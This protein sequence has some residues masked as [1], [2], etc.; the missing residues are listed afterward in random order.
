MDGSNHPEL[1]DCLLYL[2][3]RCNYATSHDGAGFNKIDAQFGN[4]LATKSKQRDLSLNQHLAARKM[5][6][7][8]RGQLA[9]G[10]LL[11]PDY[12]TIRAF[13]ANREA[14][15]AEAAANRPP[16]ELRIVG[17]RLLVSFPFNLEF[18]HALR[19]LAMSLNDARTDDG[20]EAAHWHWDQRSTAWNLPA[21]WLEP[22]AGLF[23][24]F[25][26]NE[27]AK[28]RIAAFEAEREAAQ[29]RAEAAIAAR[30]AE[31]NGLLALV[32]LD[33]DFAGR[34]LRPY[35]KE[36]IT[37]V[38][39]QE[40]LLL[41]DD[42][43]LGKTLQSAVV[44]TA[45]QKLYDC[46]AFI[47]CRAGLTGQWTREIERNPLRAEIY[48]N[49]YLSIPQPPNRPFVLTVDEC[50]DYANPKAKR[51]QALLRLANSEH[52]KS[53]I[54]LSGT[55]MDN[56]DPAALLPLLQ[57]LRHPLAK[58]PVKFKRR[59]CKG[60]PS[61]SR[62]VATGAAHLDELRY[63]MMHNPKCFLRRTKKEHLK[64]LPPKTRVLHSFELEGAAKTAYA[65][66]FNELRANYWERVNNGTI[67]SQGEALVILGNLRRA[68]SWANQ[69][70][71]IR[72]GRQILDGGEQVVIFTAYKDSAH[73]I[74]T[75]L[76]AQVL[77]G[78]VKPKDR[79]DMIQRFQAGQRRA[80]VCIHGT[81]GVGIELTAAS[82]VILHDR[83]FAPGKNIQAED[84]LHR[85][86]Q[87]NPVTALW[88]QSTDIQRRIDDI[89]I[90]KHERTELV[91]DGKRKTFNG[92][93]DIGDMAKELL[94]EFFAKAS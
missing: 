27:A 34:Q 26:T 77:N 66:R 93:T 63:E 9:H 37:T 76:D 33:G 51:T 1:C 45:Y 11:L 60:K 88:I 82:W 49:H 6:Q 80:I 12:D 29:R 68:S 43:G 41:A 46:P 40:R 50:Q 24:S 81:G 15:K 44:M 73:N 19:D 5:M 39:E 67:S 42:M 18:N 59:F 79:D 7:K 57:M 72:L 74:A 71:T 8:Y 55:P 23:P 36:G 30:K 75:A 3:E 56:G 35:Q 78:E 70:E 48:S 38:F 14:A 53:I 21:Q 89:L 47:L 91:L 65:N 52:C 2:S 61:K 54:L 16:G 32:D 84:R 87:D 69:S 64:D 85:L 25:A 31:I 94:E 83:V 17:D 22:F 90:A 62:S 86:G 28:A 92:I 10:G 20:E 4:D 58:N 13:V